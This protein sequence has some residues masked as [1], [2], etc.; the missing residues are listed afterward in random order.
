M[1]PAG[2]HFRS[3]WLALKGRRARI[4]DMAAGIDT[5][6]TQDRRGPVDRVRSDTR[7]VRVDVSGI[8]LADV[9]QLARER[10]ET[11]VHVEHRDGMTYLVADRDRPA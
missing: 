6:R 5:I 1:A 2:F 4:P 7:L 9:R 8:P 11:P 3:A 10:G